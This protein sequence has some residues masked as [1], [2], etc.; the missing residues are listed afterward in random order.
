MCKL[1]SQV[2][3]QGD[4]IHGVHLQPLQLG[5]PSS[6]GGAE[7]WHSIDFRCRAKKRERAKKQEVMFRQ[8]NEEGGG[9]GGL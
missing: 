2:S 5:R 6:T 4:L 7:G 8:S 1:V 9:G 3:D